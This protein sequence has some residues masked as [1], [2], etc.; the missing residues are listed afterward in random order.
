[1]FRYLS[2][3]AL[4]LS[5]AAAMA[6]GPSYSYIQASYQEI[7]IDL[8]GGFDVDGDGFGVSG[9]V[10]INDSWYV[11][12]SYGSAELENVVDLDQLGLGVGWHSPISETMDWFVSAAYVSAE[13]SANGFG[14][15]DDSGYGVGLGLRSM[16]NPR[17]EL[18]GSINYADLGDGGDTSLGLAAWYTIS[19]NFAAGIGADFGDDIS[20]YG[21]GIRLYFDK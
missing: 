8:G 10:A 7:D 5:S 14:S 16:I 11:F 15:A 12:A 13:V 18:A 9:S 21:I 2:I 20:S 19:G 4:M 3:G 1:M 17:L 6:E